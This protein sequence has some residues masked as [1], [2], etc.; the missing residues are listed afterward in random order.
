MAADSGALATLTVPGDVRPGHY[1][2]VLDRAG[3]RFRLLDADEKLVL[4][5][6]TPG[7][8]IGAAFGLVWVP[9]SGAVRPGGSVDFTVTTTSEAALV[10]AEELRIRA[11][12]EGN[13]VRIARRGP[14]PDQA[15]GIANAVAERFV[16]AAADLKRQRL[17]ELTAILQDQ[18]NH[19]QANLRT[20]EAALTV[21]R[22]HNAVRPSEGPAQGPDGRR[23]TADPTFASYVDR[24]VAFDGLTRDRAAIAQVLTHADS[25][26]AVDQ[27]AMI[28]A[29]QRSSELTA[30][31]KE[32]TDRQAELRALRFRYADTHPPVR[33]LALQVDTLAQRVIPGLARTLMDGLAARAR[34]LAQRRDSI[35]RDLQSAPPV[36]LTEIRLARAALSGSPPGRGEHATRRAHSGAGSSADAPGQSDRPTP[37]H[38]GVLDELRRRGGGSGGA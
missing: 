17:T 27:L 26:V 1:R 16:A 38:R 24:Q 35:A 10:L 22:V 37:H 9:P 14:D 7:E 28:G 4:Q 12:P 3:K 29:V 2:L 23:I 33:R 20:A 34:E 8:A 36:A 11:A 31:L 19:A 15:T 6:A 13:F 21:F 25:G 18:L 32:L 5:E 30:A